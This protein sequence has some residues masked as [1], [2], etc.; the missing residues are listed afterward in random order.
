MLSGINKSVERIG[1]ADEPE[2]I[3]KAS[4]GRKGDILARNKVRRDCDY[5]LGTP[6]SH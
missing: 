2:S 4:D 5:M 6:A 1:V 3:S